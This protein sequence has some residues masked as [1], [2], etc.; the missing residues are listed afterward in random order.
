MLAAHSPEAIKRGAFVVVIG[1]IHPS[2]NGVLYPNVLKLEPDVLAAATR[3]YADD[4]AAVVRPALPGSLFHRA[5]HYVPPECPA[6]TLLDISWPPPNPARARVLPVGELVVA[7]DVEGRLFVSTRD[8]S[9][10]LP[11]RT[12]VDSY[13]I[14]SAPESFK[15]LQGAH[16]P[17]V[18]VDGA[19]LWRESWRIPSPTAGGRDDAAVFL[20]VRRWAREHGLP[21][22]VFVKSAGE[23]KPFL[24]DFDNPFL[25]EALA[26]IS[27]KVECV[28]ISEM[29][30]VPE[31]TWLPDAAGRR[32]TCEL[33]MCVV[34]PTALMADQQPP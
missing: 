22:R 26:H 33:R 13:L 19:V 27:S 25:V 17:R 7:A 30:P 23:S 21:R 28:D 29:L 11:F 32:Y 5:V 2:A 8:G 6:L 3:A 24:V 10:R 18:T 31:D 14:G 1:E 20:A 16:V 34:D 4:L 9:V 15:L 12:T